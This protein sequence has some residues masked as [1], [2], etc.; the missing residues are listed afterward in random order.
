MPKGIYKRIIGV[1]CGF[2]LGKKFSD[3]IRKKLSVAHKGQ[4]SSPKTEFKKGKHYSIKTEFKKGKLTGNKHPCWKGGKVKSD[5]H[6]L[7][8]KSDHPFASKRD[9][10][11][12]E[13]RLVMEKH[14][15]RY[16]KPKEVVHHINEDSLD[17]RLENLM[18]FSNQNEHTKYHW[19]IKKQEMEIKSFQFNRTF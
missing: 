15:G 14:L 8:Y 4:H 2:N 1:N 19:R 16:L 17:N 3:E 13:H 7:I 5:N 18:L 9:K 6:W 12:L 10:Y 11:V